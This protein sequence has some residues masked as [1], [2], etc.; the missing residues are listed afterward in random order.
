MKAWSTPSILL[1]IILL[2]G[3]IPGSTISP[4]PGPSPQTPVADKSSKGWDTLVTEAKKE[5]KVYVYTNLSQEA[6]AAMAKAISDKYNI[7]V[8]FYTAASAQLTEKVLSERRSGMNIAGMVTSGPSSMQALKTAGVLAPIP[9]LLVLPEMTDAKVWP[10]GEP[11]YLDKD[12][13]IV[14]LLASLVLYVI[15]NPEVVK[16]EE[17]TTADDLLKPAFKNKIVMYDPSSPG[18]SSNW[19]AFMLHVVKTPDQGKAFLK[20]LA[21]QEPAITRDYRQLV[22]WVAKGKYP[23]GIGGSQQIVFEFQKA[24]APVIFARMKEGGIM[25]PGETTT[26]MP[27]DPSQPNASKLLLN[28]LLTSEGQTVLGNAVGKSSLRKDTQIQGLE[29]S[30]I[31]LPG[32]KVF[33]LTEEFIAQTLE[34]QTIAKDIFGPLIGK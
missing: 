1:A 28:W 24:G 2:A 5:G 8:E 29:P 20:Q 21:A 17:L 15:V 30:G 6:R 22:E 13:T 14:S 3:C 11:P 4:T 9:P 34:A 23:I 18:S 10:A 12:K 19:V 25:H 7:E 26:A 33:N 27:K 16:A 32:E 31:P